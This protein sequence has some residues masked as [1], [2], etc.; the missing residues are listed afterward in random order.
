VS[1]QPLHPALVS[2]GYRISTTTVLHL[3][4]PTGGMVVRILICGRDGRVSFPS[5]LRPSGLISFKE[6]KLSPSDHLPWGSRRE[7]QPMIEHYPTCC[8]KALPPDSVV[9]MQICTWKFTEYCG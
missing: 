7:A 3:W 9:P 1:V 4:H 8:I 5:W 6:E 2:S